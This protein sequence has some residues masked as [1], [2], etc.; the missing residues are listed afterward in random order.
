MK[1]QPF[2]NSN[3]NDKFSC[4]FRNWRKD[5]ERWKVVIDYKFIFNYLIFSL[6]FSK[7][8]KVFHLFIIHSLK[9]RLWT[10]LVVS[11]T[12]SP[13]WPYSSNKE[14][15]WV[16]FSLTG[17]H[18]QWDKPGRVYRRYAYKL[19]YHLEFKQ[20]S[21]Q[22]LFTILIKGLPKGI[23]LTNYPTSPPSLGLIFS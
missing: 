2:R 5:L 13:S 23:L 19:V 7:F 22:K 17:V 16:I 12:W 4:F 9:L 8:L 20:F 1:V 21:N 14:I 3:T 11:T 18:L 10:R 15:N 6:F